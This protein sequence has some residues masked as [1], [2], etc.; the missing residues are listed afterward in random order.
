[1]IY[2]SL[3]FGAFQV[4]LKSDRIDCQDIVNLKDWIQRVFR[5]GV[6]ILVPAGSR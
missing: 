6:L 5:C 1:M 2:L 4:F 3:G